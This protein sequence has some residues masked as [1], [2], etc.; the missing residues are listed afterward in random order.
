MDHAHR[1][2]TLPLPLA[3]LL[4]RCLN[5]KS[6]V[7]RH[8]H[9]FF[10]AEA[11][12]R[13]VGAA[14]VGAWLAD[15]APAPTL[16]PQLANLRR[17]SL[18]H[19]VGWIREVR[20]AHAPPVLTF[21][22]GS[23]EATEAWARAVARHEVLAPS[24]VRS[25]RRRGPLGFFEALTTYRNSVMGH[26]AQRVRAYYEEVTPLLLEAVLE[27]LRAIPWIEQG[28]LRHTD[29]AS[30]VRLRGLAALPEASNDSGTGL[31]VF[32]PTW[33]TSL[34]PF[35]RHAVDTT[36]DRDRVVYLNRTT[37]RGGRV[38]NA[39]YL[40][41]STGESVR[42]DPGALDQVFRDADDDDPSGGAPEGYVLGEVLGSGAMGVVRRAHQT[43][44]DRPV[45]LK[46]L[47]DALAVD[48]V[49]RKRFAREVRSL[50]RCDHPHVVKVLAAGE[51]D[52]TPYFAMELIEGSDLRAHRNDHPPQWWIERLVGVAD[53]L[54]HLH[55]HGIVHRDVKPANLMLTADGERIVIMDLG[56]ARLADASVGLT[57][58]DGQLVG[59][60]RYMAPE[61]LTGNASDVD[62]RADVYGLGVTLY[63]LLTG[64]RWFDGDSR[65]RLM[66][67][68]LHERPP[69]A[70]RVR[71]GLPA[72]IDDVVARATALR[73][74]DRYRSAAALRDDLARVARGERVAR[75]KRPTSWRKVAAV[76]ALPALAVVLGGVALAWML[77]GPHVVEVGDL[78]HTRVA[79]GSLYPAFGPDGRQAWLDDPRTLRVVSDA[80][81]HTIDLGADYQ[82]ALWIGGTPGAIRK[83]PAHW[84]IVRV[85]DGTAAT[86][87][88]PLD[89]K[90]Q[91]APSFSREG[92]T[93]MFPTAS[94]L[95]LRDMATGTTRRLN[96]EIRSIAGAAWSPS[97][98]AVAVVDV[99][100]S[101][102]TI[103]VVKIHGGE[104][105]EVAS[106]FGLAGLGVGSVAWPLPT[107]LLFMAM[108]KERRHEL[109]AVDPTVPG[110]E[111]QRLISFT[112]GV[113]VAGLQVVG[114]R[115]YYQQ[116][117]LVRDTWVLDLDT[118]RHE[119]WAGRHLFGWVGDTLWVGDERLGLQGVTSA[120]SRPMPPPVAD[121]SQLHG[122]AGGLVGRASD[123]VPWSF[124]SSDTP[125]PVVSDVVGPLS[126]DGNR[127]LT[128][129]IHEGMLQ[130]TSLSPSTGASEMLFTR[131]TTHSEDHAGGVPAYCAATDSI[132]LA[133]TD[134]LVVLDT[135]GNVV[136][137]L[138]P[139][140]GNPQYVTWSRDCL[141]LY[142]SGMSGDTAYELRRHDLTA[143]TQQI[144]LGSDHT[145]F[146][147][148]ALSPDGRKLAH[149]QL[150]FEHATW[151][152][153]GLG[154]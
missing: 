77:G 65:E 70:S 131:P 28:R 30:T 40:D 73:P 145:W 75:T 1:V 119:P 97:G 149:R 59:T 46:T 154:L 96:A 62:G 51:R 80:G 34:E 152:V 114:D 61:Q 135:A 15:E 67:Q 144:V 63:E 78:Q 7:E 85:V 112:P 89:R 153:D 139:G 81:S 82:E 45:A 17:A 48:P 39:D 104:V 6:A 32:G 111:P 25:L 127:C 68:I 120:E 115:I 92:H 123:E 137:H 128:W 141:T 124:V 101:P 133:T 143:G 24:L 150:A 31:H 113:N 69:P 91:G 16:R 23:T 26:S 55:D 13:L 56:L 42:L 83:E 22:E 140:M 33:T 109:W 29:E 10:L 108:T 134:E 18:G 54:Q 86:M 8:H 4:V 148:L 21:D 100:T 151:Y 132:A 110:A 138:P 9:T 146:G 47:S 102:Y 76:T 14:A 79:Q 147:P 11:S 12:L 117:D 88:L 107:T 95:Q 129:T 93:V 44:L 103:S 98:E 3:Q 20:R 53:G 37:V 72:G 52:G 122:V 125:D 126:C 5:G 58:A 2:Q 105:R 27:Q 136:R 90:M 87:G 99:T 130:V 36:L 74:G 41:Y 66:H 49:A 64:A 142:V 116:T 57:E 84:R 19:W 94:G 35:V 121:W 38:R 60:L 118:G 50:A 106:M 43:N 71:D